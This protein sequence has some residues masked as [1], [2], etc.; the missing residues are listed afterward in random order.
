MNRTVAKETRDSR[1]AVMAAGELA[2]NR[3]VWRNKRWEEDKTTPFTD[4]TFSEAMAT[5]LEFYKNENAAY[6]YKKYAGPASKNLKAFF[7]ES[8]TS[9]S[10]SNSPSRIRFE[11]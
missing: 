6:T 10:I 3:R 9:A 5:F 8:L 11:T 1:K 7:D 4:P 2:V